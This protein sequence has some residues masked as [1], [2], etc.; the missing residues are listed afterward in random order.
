[1][2]DNPI[3]ALLLAIRLIFIKLKTIPTTNSVIPIISVVIIITF[4]SLTIF[5]VFIYHS[6]Q[7]KSFKVL[8]SALHI[9]IHNFKLGLSL[10]ASIKFIVCLVTPTISASCSCDTSDSILPI[11]IFLFFKKHP[12]LL[13]KSYIFI[14]LYANYILHFVMCQD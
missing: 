14:L 3:I 7:N 2:N 12:L 1:M 8:F 4:D 9:S 11:F 10:P 13:F 6:S 5:S